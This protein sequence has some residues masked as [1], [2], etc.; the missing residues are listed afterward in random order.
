MAALARSVV[1]EWVPQALRRGIDLGFEC[2][3]ASAPAEGL[4]LLIRELMNNLIDNA[5]Q[6]TPRGGSVTVRVSRRGALAPGILLEVE[7]TGSGIPEP[8]QSRIFDRFYQV[9]GSPSEGSGLGLAIVLEIADQHQ[10]SVSV[11]SPVVRDAESGRDGG[12]R[13]QVLFTEPEAGRGA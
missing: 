4:P 3:V 10:A 11:F 5:L 1:G 12:T 9:L 7:D 8:D 13:F 2:E 6:H